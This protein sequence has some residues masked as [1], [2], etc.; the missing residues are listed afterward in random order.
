MSCLKIKNWTDVTTM[1]I[2]FD[3]NI[4]KYQANS[5]YKFVSGWV[6]HL[7]LL[8]SVLKHINFL[9]MDI[10]RGS[11]TTR[12]RCSGIF[13]NAFIA[14]LLVSPSVKEFWKSVG[15]WLSYG[16]KSSVLFFDSQCNL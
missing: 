12:L 9:N 1:Q 16:Q 15:I 7:S 5:I 4:N 3:F 14:N 6:L 11:V 2:I 13:N 10:S 8:H